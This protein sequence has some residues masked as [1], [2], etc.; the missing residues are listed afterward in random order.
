MSMDSA[1]NGHWNVKNG[2]FFVF[3]V[4]GTR[5]SGTVWAKYSCSSE[6]SYLTLLENA[7]Y[8]WVLNYH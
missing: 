6:R 3:T 1:Q 4:N 8:Y 5:K 7:M 2:L